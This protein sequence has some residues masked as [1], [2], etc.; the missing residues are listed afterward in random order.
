[1]KWTWTAEQNDLM[2][3]IQAPIDSAFETNVVIHADCKAGT[4]KTTLVK[5]VVR[6]NPDKIYVYTAFNR[7]IVQDGVKSFG[8][9]HC[10]TFHAFARMYINRPN[11]GGFYPYLVKT[12]AFT[13]P[14][15][16]M[17]VDML[18]KYCLSRHLDLDDFLDEHGIEEHI[19]EVILEYLEKMADR[20]MSI[21]FNYMLKELHHNLASGDTVITLDMLFVD[22]AQDLT[23]VMLEIFGLIQADVKVYLGDT[24]QAIYSFLDLVSAFTLSTSTYTLT[25][26]FRLSKAIAAKIEPFCQAFIDPSFKITGVSTNTDTTE[27][28]ITHSN[29]EIVQH[30]MSRQQLGMTY[31]FTKPVADIFEVTMAVNDILNG[32]P[33]KKPKYWGLVDKVKKRIPLKQLGHDEE[34]DDDIQNSV[35]LIAHFRS[36][37]V[38]VGD[39][40]AKAETD[41]V[42]NE[43]L[44]G[45]AHSV[46]GT[47]FGQVTISPGLNKF[48]SKMLLEVPKT[49]EEAEEITEACMLYYVACSR[50]KHS[51][52]NADQLAVGGRVREF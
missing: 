2:D 27:A 28:F 38:D 11:I 5:E 51:L 13:Y 52:I 47:E 24:S 41:P 34:L 23:P 32:I 36:V 39:V 16:K 9:E 20:K 49:D 37:R 17:V 22:E 48:V 31:S 14:E 3:A 35:R 10:K 42:N 46:K 29:A 40:L 33:S 19:G 4:G 43:Y 7:K 6:R 44:I 18:D 30:V 45:T 21:T 26:S 1:M 8:A 12:H 25:T 50:A 15:K